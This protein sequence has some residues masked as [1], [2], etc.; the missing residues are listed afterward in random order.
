MAST[1]KLRFW[2]G[3]LVLLAL[4]VSGSVAML[5]VFSMLLTEN[6]EM[7][8]T[9][10]LSRAASAIIAAQMKAKDPEMVPDSL[11]AL[12]MGTDSSITLMDSGGN[13][14]YRDTRILDRMKNLIK[15]N[16]DWIQSPHGPFRFPWP[17]PEIPDSLSEIARRLAQGHGSTA[18]LTN[19]QGQQTPILPDGG[20]VLR[21]IPV[22]NKPA[23]ASC[24][25]YD[26][27][28]LGHLVVAT[29]VPGLLSPRKSLSFW[30]LL[31]FTR[32]NQKILAGISLS[33]FGLFLLILVPV[34]S[35]LIGRKLKRKPSTS[36][37]QTKKKEEETPKKEGGRTRVF[38][39]EETPPQGGE[40][41]SA[42]REGDLSSRLSAIDQALAQ[43]I[44]GLPHAGIQGKKGSP[45][46]ETIQKAVAT[47]QEWSDKVELLLMDLRAR[48]EVLSDP[49]V[50]RAIEKLTTLKDEALTLGQTVEEVALIR[51]VP[52]FENLDETTQVWLE[53]MRKHLVQIHGEIRALRGMLS[54][55]PLSGK[56]TEK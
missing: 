55:K 40:P 53:T 20:F 25:G 50:T 10:D 8:K 5:M 27:N 28:V 42:E 15:V 26:Q 4:V 41:L 22:L 44:E 21:V 49:M 3:R 33:L 52:S 34:D 11:A 32:T 18:F 16:P 19:R 30:G 6:R 46:D 17:P 45:R 48:G 47:F 39:E 35:L 51:P 9:E 37:G 56:E 14:A 13:P 54:E 29:P 23:C 31:P 1:P 43:E 24:H 12:A 38:A 7:K 2:P 36:A